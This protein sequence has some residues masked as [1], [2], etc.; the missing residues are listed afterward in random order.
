MTIDPDTLSI[1][2]SMTDDPKLGSKVTAARIGIGRATLWRMLTRQQ[3]SDR[4]IRRVL[5]YIETFET[6]KPIN[7]RKP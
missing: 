1:I 2:Q 4:I 3:A 5:R 7:G 6:S